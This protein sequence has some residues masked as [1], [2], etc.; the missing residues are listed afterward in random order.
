MA[1]DTSSSTRERPGFLRRHWGKLTLAGLLVIPTAV[2]AAWTAV[3]MAFTYSRGERV[4][5]AQKL[6]E[7]GWLC[8]TWEGELTMNAL[9]GAAPEK[10]YYT[11]RDDSLARVIQAFDGKRVVL[12]YEQHRG[13][14]LS[15]V[16]ETE[17]F[18]TGVRAG[19]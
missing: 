7:K 13:V 14:P 3:A 4:G 1:S 19:Q 9:P 15:C 16:G 6:S 12:D 11:V 10:F 2:L 17:Y 8:R 5:F 18:V